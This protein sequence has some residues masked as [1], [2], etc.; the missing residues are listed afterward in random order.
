MQF[1][2]LN[3]LTKTASVVCAVVTVLIVTL[4][5][6]SHTLVSRRFAA[7]EEKESKIQVQQAVNELKNALQKV[8]SSTKD[9]APWDETYQFVQDG[10]RSYVEGNMQDA[11]FV[12][13]HLSFMLFYDAQGQLVQQKFFDLGESKEAEQDPEVLETISGTAQLMLHSSQD[14]HAHVSGVLV[15]PSGKLLLV[16]A[17]PIVTSTFEGPVRGTLLMGHCLDET[18]IKRMN[19]ENSL[20]MRVHPYQKMET[21]V[22]ADQ[23]R[24]KDLLSRGVYVQA[25]TGRTIAGYAVL[26]DVSGRPA[27][28]VEVTRDREVFQQGMGMWKQYAVTLGVVGCVFIVVLLGLL[29]RF[30]LHKLIRVTSEVDRIADTGRRDLRLTVRGKDEIGHLAER[31]NSMLGGLEQYQNMQEE[32][33]D[34]LKELLDSINCGIMV[35]NAENRRI[36]DINKAGAAMLNRQTEEVVGQQCHQFICPREFNNCPVLDHGE[37]IELSERAVLRADG[38]QL[39]VLKSVTSVERHGQRY[40]IESFIDISVLKETQRELRNSEAKYRQFF[41]EDLTSNFIS[42][43]DGRILDCNPAFAKML[44]YQTVEEAKQG[45]I[46]NHYFTSADREAILE[47]IRQEKRLERHEWKFRHMN[48]NPIYCVG[49]AIGVFDQQGKPKEYRAYVF[50]DTRRVVLEKDMR[51]SQKLEAI[52]TLAGGIA[53]DFN[54]ILAGIMGYTEI[55]MRDLAD[56]AT[57]RIQQYLNNILSGGERARDLIQ[58]ILAFSRQSDMELKPVLVQQAVKEVIQLIRAS[59]PATIAIEQHLNS[60]ATV[61]ADQA[62]MHQIIMNLCTNAGHAMKGKGGTLTL[63]LE[64]IILDQTF[65]DIYRQLE[66]GPYV[67]LRVSDTGE[68]IPER[69]QDRIFDPFFTT[70]KKGEGT[71]LGLSLVHGIVSSMKGLVTVDSVVG[72]GTQFDI[73]LPRI[74]H[75]LEPARIEQEIMPSGSEH[76]VYVDDDPFLVEIGKEILIGL[77]YRITDFSDSAKAL[78]YLGEHHAEVDLLVTDMTMPKVTGLDLIRSLRQQQSRVPVI[79]CTGHSEGLTEEQ[80]AAQG[81]SD[82]VLKPIT[83]RSLAEKVRAV[84][85]RSKAGATDGLS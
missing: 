17:A 66:P 18:E 20:A 69:L 44:G 67:R 43:P 63:Q 54:N 25:V 5:I 15:T 57:P 23:I 33:K 35:I 27:I 36:V 13:L 83:V 56:S 73:Y 31:I 9:Y 48:G 71:G 2:N 16:A 55:V 11:T 39:F 47:R 60:Q 81:V 72:Q 10:N 59:L 75:S 40:L 26:A 6:S 12:N 82:F 29:N 79:L 51:Q 84:L 52:G 3:I 1:K 4:A 34:Y 42:T 22:P 28:T 80:V 64:D 32:N 77:G 24:G 8:A 49:N 14:V 85:D 61:M 38:S 53:H 62:Q 50:D 78:R 41:E 30:I 70:K 76:I 19:A 45:N 65:T 58:Q 37:K 46:T 68:G 21:L 74:N 7:L